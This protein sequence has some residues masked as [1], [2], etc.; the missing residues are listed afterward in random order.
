MA[1][2]APG[3]G[4]TTAEQELRDVREQF[5]A[6][7][8]ILSALGRSGTDPD[9]VLDTIVARAAA[10]CRADVAQL[11]LVRG[12]RFELSRIFGPA[13]QGFLDQVQEHPLMVSRS[14]LLG[15][16][17]LDRRTQQIPDVLADPAYGRH[18]LQRL[19]GYR[20]LF[21]APMI[22]D[23]DVVGVLSLWRYEVDPFDE[24]AAEVMEAFAA[25]AAIALKNVALLGALESRT[26]E[27]A[28]KVEEL[29]SLR[30]VGDAVS[31]IL[32]LA[33][34]L[35]TVVTHAVRI[36]AHGRRVDHGVHRAG[37]RLLGARCLRDQRL[38]PRRS[39]W[40]A[41]RAG[42]DTRR[43]G[44]PATAPARRQR[45]RYGAARPALADSA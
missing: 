4:Q 26:A 15:R 19:A 21:E 17:V 3:D 34:V 8:E 38:A 41:D 11:Y 44:G 10:L 20:T 30:E 33:E 2:A 27:L 45:P 16:V 32:D 12:D 9:S 31:S 23:E 39:A 37:G 7:K 13:P 36:T 29:E 43:P 1:A 25:Q 22:V 5:A 42:F 28:T 40:R 14:S 18:D 35:Q 24:R 6:T